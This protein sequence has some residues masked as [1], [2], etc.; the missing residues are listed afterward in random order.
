M[1]NRRYN[2]GLL[3]AT[4]TD[5][6]SNRIAIGAME[7]AKKLDANLIIFPGKYLGVQHINEQYGAKYEYQYHVLFDL[8]AEAKLDYLIIAVGTIGYALEHT[9]QKQFLDRFGD[10][11]ILSVAFETK[12]YPF[13]QFDDYT[14]LAAAVDYL[15]AHGRKHIGMMVGDITNEGYVRRYETYR[16]RLEAN[17]LEFKD[18]YIM[19]SNL[20]VHCFPEIEEL[21]DKNP[22]LDALMCT[23]DI[24]AADVCKVLKQKEIGI[25]TDIAVV[26]FDDLPIDV[27]LDPPLASVRADAVRLGLRAVEKAINDLNGVEDTSRY[28]ES[29]FIPRQSCFQYVD[30]L[31]VSERIFCGDFT[32]VADHIKDYFAEIG[33]DTAKDRY[34]CEQLIRILEHLYQHY[35]LQPV[36]ESVIE[37]TVSMLHE[38]M[39]LK[40][41][42]KIDQILDGAHIWLLRSCPVGNIPYVKMLHQYFRANR[43]EESA[44]SVT[45]KFM[46]RSHNNNIFIRD[47]LMFSGNHKNSYALILEKLER[48]G[49]VSAFLYTLDQPIIHRYGDCFPDH[50]MWRFQS[51]SAGEKAFS[52]PEE[53][54]IMSTPEVF[55]NPYFHQDRQHVLVATPLYSAQT[56]YGMALLEPRDK[57]FFDEL[58]LVTFHLSSAVRTLDMLKKQEELFKQQEKLLEK[59]HASNLAL[60]KLSKTDGLTKVYNRKGF[61]SAADQLIKDTRYQDKP[62]II[63]YADMDDLK[64]VNDTYGHAEG[65]FSIRLVAK[66]L[67]DVLGSNAI[68]GRMGGDEFAAVLPVISNVTVEAL[69]ERKEQFIRRFNESQE[70]PYPFGLSIGMLECVCRDSYDLKAAL[71]KADD[72]L[73]VE[74]GKKKKKIKA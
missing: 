70:K 22:D 27:K 71:D 36:E 13:L 47:A 51:Y 33:K 50:A 5:E 53:A 69:M 42:S 12:D 17:G 62:L 73:Y 43:N 7:A 28:I 34:S 35:V 38:A 56:Q 60:E 4:I 74:K 67:A 25:G 58:E 30:D 11:P 39:W 49:A 37:N 68:I 24:I 52:V 19:P 40:E 46:D 55:H 10:T 6:F 45:R 20:A 26:G 48:I 61:Y 16:Q 2:I 21:L 41:D 32:A 72:L 1:E 14:G 31:N 44:E 54:Q 8:A 65:D 64:M 29:E 66:C 15:A 18:S 57:D 3:V 23:T 9:K 59:L 63:C